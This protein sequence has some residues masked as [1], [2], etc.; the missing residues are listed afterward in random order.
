M[1]KYYPFLILA[2]LGAAA[3]VGLIFTRPREARRGEGLATSAA[4]AVMQRFGPPLLL[5]LALCGFVLWWIFLRPAG[6]D[7]ATLDRLRAAIRDYYSSGNV[8]ML[9]D[10]ANRFHATGF[11]KTPEFTLSCDATVDEK[12]EALWRCAP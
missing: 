10:A 2:G 1:E 5:T 3:T 9:R 12:G 6:F 11:V 4:E 8:V 7:D